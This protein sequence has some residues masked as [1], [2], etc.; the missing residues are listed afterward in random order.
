MSAKRSAL[1]PVAKSLLLRSGFYPVFRRAVPSRQVAILRYHAVCDPHAGYA[2]PGI[3]VSP[4][5]FEAHVRY[6][7]HNYAVLPL[8]GGG[9]AA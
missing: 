4:E 6:L 7:A 5:A 1:A 8:P 2:E 3:C 9:P